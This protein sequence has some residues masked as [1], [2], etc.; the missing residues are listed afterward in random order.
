MRESPRISRR[1]GN[2][3]VLLADLVGNRSRRRR[4]KNS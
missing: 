4:K 3:V 2:L 1:V